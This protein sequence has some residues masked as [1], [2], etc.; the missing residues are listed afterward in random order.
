MTPAVVDASVVLKW[1][2]GSRPGEGEVEIALSLLRA[3]AAGALDMVQPPHFIAEVGAVL[4]RETPATAHRDL[5]DLMELDMRVAAQPGAYALAMTLADRYRLHLFDTLYHALALH[6]DGAV[7]VTADER[8]ER[9][10]RGEGR[11]VL[12]RDFVLPT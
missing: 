11:V 6:T 10:A 2:L 7:F 5:A 4:I 9:S 12:L 3:V 1:F 8:Y